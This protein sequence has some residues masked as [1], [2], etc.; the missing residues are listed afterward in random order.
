M[1]I[2]TFAISAALRHAIIPP[3]AK[4]APAAT[5]GFGR[6][7]VRTVSTSR[8]NQAASAAVA[9]ADQ[10]VPDLYS[11]D[12]ETWRPA[13]ARRHQGELRR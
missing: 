3:D 2:N 13:L 8:G 7:L 1:A 9:G 6:Y 11:C 12:D 4:D 10:N 5:T